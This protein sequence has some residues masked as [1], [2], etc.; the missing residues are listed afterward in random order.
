M[1]V[2]KIL[3]GTVRLN[4]YGW[5]G[6]PIGHMRGSRGCRLSLSEMRRR[7]EWKE[8]GVLNVLE[9]RNW[10]REQMKE[11]KRWQSRRGGQQSCVVRIVRNLSSYEKDWKWNGWQ[12]GREGVC[13]DNFV[14]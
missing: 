2:G 7:Q 11:R 5:S 3:V 12:R 6:S 13:R 9:G 10:Q 14:G 8:K 4:G 1:F